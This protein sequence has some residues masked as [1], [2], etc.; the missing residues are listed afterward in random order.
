MRRNNATAPVTAVL[1]LVLAVC[2]PRGAYALPD[3]FDIHYER[4]DTHVM[5]YFTGHPEYEAIEAFVSGQQGNKIRVT[6]TAHDQTQTD[7][8]NDERT[9][10]AIRASGLARETNFADVAYATTVKKGIP[11]VTLNFTTGKGERIAFFLRSAGKTSAKYGGLVD[12]ERHSGTS[13]LPIIYREASTLADE[14]SFVE[15]DGTR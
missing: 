10:A 3:P 5:L 2:A 4:C 12:P 11:E 6:I 7:Y 1:A 14:D 9:V 8:L 15:I 13:S